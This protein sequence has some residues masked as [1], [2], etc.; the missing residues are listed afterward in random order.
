LGIGFDAL[1]DILAE[2][3]TDTFREL[4]KLTGAEQSARARAFEWNRDLLNNPPR[5]GTKYDD[6]I[7]EIECLFHVMCYE[8]NRLSRTGPEFQQ[9]VLELGAIDGIKR[10]EWFIHQ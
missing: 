10:T 6:A 2:E 3:L 5:R 4:N 7:G 8:D 1:Q 9:Q